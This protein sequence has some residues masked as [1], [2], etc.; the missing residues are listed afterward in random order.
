[1]FSQRSVLL[2]VIYY[3]ILYYRHYYS[4]DATRS[5]Y[6]A[7]CNRIV[8]Y[9][10]HRRRC[11]YLLI[12]YTINV[13]ATYSILH[14]WSLIEF[15][16]FLHTHHIVQFILLFNFHH[17]SVFFHIIPRFKYERS[18]FYSIFSFH[19]CTRNRSAIKYVVKYI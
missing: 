4:T 8:L 9:Y 12:I 19:L 6:L 1:M 5:I 11:R 18:V 13:V 2:S 16:I 10:R 14:M 17:N 7:P 15:T 3:L